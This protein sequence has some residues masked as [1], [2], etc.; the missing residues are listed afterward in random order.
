MGNNKDDWGCGG[1]VAFFEIIGAIAGVI[2]LLWALGIV[3]FS[4]PKGFPLHV[5]LFVSETPTSLDPMYSTSMPGPNCDKGGARWGSPPTDDAL[6]YG[7]DSSNGFWISRASGGKYIQTAEFL[8][9]GGKLSADVNLRVT[10]RLTGSMCAGVRMRE[11]FGAGGYD[12]LVCTDGLYLVASNSSASGHNVNLKAATLAA[13][14]TYVLIAS[15]KGS[16]LTLTIDGN[17]VFTGEDS[18]YPT[19]N[20]CGLLV[21]ND[22]GR[23]YFSDFTYTPL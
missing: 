4:L 8:G 13:K 3:T 20:G 23:A 11:G 10:V 22:R 9:Q 16:T 2:G 14:D 6:S 17:S 19:A 21:G 7:C 18:E 1:V 15:T 12:F 5:P